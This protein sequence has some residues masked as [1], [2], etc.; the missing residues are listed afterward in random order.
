M[1]LTIQNIY[2]CS[3][4]ADSQIRS[5]IS[6]EVVVAVGRP[7][8]ERRLLVDDGTAA[9]EEAAEGCRIR[10]AAVAEL[11]LGRR[12][13]VAVLQELVE[14]AAARAAVE[15]EGGSGSVAVDGALV[16]RRRR[17][18]DLGAVL[19]AVA[20]GGLR[21]LDVEIDEVR[22]GLPPASSADGASC[23]CS[24]SLVRHDLQEGRNQR[25]THDDTDTER[26]GASIGW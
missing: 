26:G 23:S 3:I 7:R 9:A 2:A 11:H 13:R 19:A 8:P 16:G 18:G 17:P 5:W 6:L 4:Y 14:A 22:R 25:H 21:L 12:Q 10:A 15:R 1:D 20:A 24:S